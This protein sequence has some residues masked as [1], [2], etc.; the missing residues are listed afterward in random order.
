MKR[1]WLAALPAIAG[2]TRQWNCLDRSHI[3]HRRR[4]WI[5]TFAEASKVFLIRVITLTGVWTVSISIR[6]G[7]PPI[8]NQHAAQWPTKG[9]DLLRSIF[10]S[11]CIP[12][13]WDEMYRIK[14]VKTIFKWERD[15]SPVSVV[16][17]KETGDK[18]RQQ[19]SVGSCE[20]DYHAPETYLKIFDYLSYYMRPR[21]IGNKSSFPTHPTIIRTFTN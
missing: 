15:S 5:I 16:R 4:T 19:L 14:T 2:L 9:K 18:L 13:T 21:G 20:E 7:I 11:L 17:A 3:L 12:C 10:L 1:K 6:T 8:S